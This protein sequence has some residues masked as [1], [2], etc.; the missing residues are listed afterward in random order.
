MSCCSSAG[1]LYLMV[2]SLTE[3]LLDTMAQKLTSKSPDQSWD[4]KTKRCWFGSDPSSLENFG[5]QKVSL[6][7]V[8][9]GDT[10]QM[11]VYI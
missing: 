6:G 11:Y 4:V 5:M 7:G 2:T 8:V 3:V 1:W 9:R 10:F